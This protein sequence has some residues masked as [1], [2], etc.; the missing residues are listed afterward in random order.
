M[1]NNKTYTELSLFLSARGMSISSFE[2]FKPSMLS[3]V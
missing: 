3:V 2:Q 1:L